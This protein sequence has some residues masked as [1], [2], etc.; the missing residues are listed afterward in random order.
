LCF[1][2]LLAP[3]LVKRSGVLD[4]IETIED[5]NGSNNTTAEEKGEEEAGARESGKKEWE[6][7]RAGERE[8]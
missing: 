2:K 7:G 4:S 1:I 8:E 5:Q 6:S 3:S